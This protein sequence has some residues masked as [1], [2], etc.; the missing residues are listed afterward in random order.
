M[1]IQFTAK[2]VETGQ[3]ENQEQVEEHVIL[4]TPSGEPSGMLELVIK[5]PQAFGNFIIGESYVVEISPATA[6]N[7]TGN[8]DDT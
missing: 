2:N 5:D 1:R 8:P 6:A 4:H 3:N 7:D